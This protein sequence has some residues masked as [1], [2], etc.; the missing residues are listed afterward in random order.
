MLIVNV[1]TQSCTSIPSCNEE[2]CCRYEP[3]TPTQC[4]KASVSC[5]TV[6]AGQGSYSLLTEKLCCEEPDEFG[7]Q[8]EPL[9]G[10][11]ECCQ[12][13]PEPPSTCLNA[14]IQCLNLP[15]GSFIFYADRECCDAESC[16]SIPSCNVE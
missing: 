15:F 14:E 9:C 7:C 5:P 10:P 1:V 12:F 3:P 13:F 2:V 8:N 4:S 6:S 11:T 16:T